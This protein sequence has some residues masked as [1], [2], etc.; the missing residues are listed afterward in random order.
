MVLLVRLV[1]TARMGPRAIRVRK[2]NRDFRVNRVN[3][4][5]KG[6]KVTKGLLG[7]RVECCLVVRPRPVF[8]RSIGES[9]CRSDWS[10]DL[11]GLRN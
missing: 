11:F 3:L 10:P 9:S 1:P 6:K 4:V 7:P 2:V 5:Q 8:G